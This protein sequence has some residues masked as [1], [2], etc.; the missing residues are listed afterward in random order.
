MP[1][2]SKDHVKDKMMKA[3]VSD[4]NARFRKN[5]RKLKPLIK[6]LI[7]D[8]IT[9]CPEMES[10]RSGILRLDLGLTADPTSEIAA[11]VAD[12]V[13]VERDTFRYSGGMIR[14]SVRVFIQPSDNLNLLTLPSA[15]QITE[16][17]AELPW[18]DWLLHYG[19]SVIIANFGVRYKDAGRTGG[20]IMVKGTRPFRI[21]P[22]YSGVA[23]DNF[24]TRALNSKFP[25]IEGK[26]WQTILS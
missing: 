16:K 17:G 2:Q 24:V 3:Y 26:I 13:T 23:T 5:K 6:P 10:V 8:A 21:S 14:G 12:S 15:V 1:R 9:S 25:E 19:D 4:I 11:A 7:I 18:L 20:A 22:L